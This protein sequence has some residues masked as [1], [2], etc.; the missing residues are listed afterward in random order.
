MKKEDFLGGEDEDNGTVYYF[1]TLKGAKKE[2]YR[3]RHLKDK[4]FKG[5]RIIISKKQIKLDDGEKAWK[6]KIYD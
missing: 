5:N 2:L 4:Y 3:L 1:R 6:L